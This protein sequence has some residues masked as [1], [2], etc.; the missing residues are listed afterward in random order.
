MSNKYI[1]D[2]SE[3]GLEF[4]ETS[5][6]GSFELRQDADCIEQKELFHEFELMRLAIETGRAIVNDGTM[7]ATLTITV[8]VVLISSKA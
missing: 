5:Y 8:P 3:E 7:T 4:I 6:D 1:P 2:T